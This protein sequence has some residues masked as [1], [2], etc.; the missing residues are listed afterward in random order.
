M[1]TTM[2]VQDALNI[3]NVTESIITKEIIKSAY[4]TACLKYHPDHHGKAGE[5]MM[6]LVNV[7][8]GVIKK[9]L[10]TDFFDTFRNAQQ[11][12]NA[13]QEQRTNQES[14][15]RQTNDEGFAYDFGEEIFNA[16]KFIFG[17]HYDGLVVELCGNWL[18]ITGDTKP[19]KDK[20]KD[21]RNQEDNNRFRWC[22]KKVAWSYRP[23]EWKSSNRRAWSMDQIRAGHG[24]R[25]FRRKEE[26]ET[27]A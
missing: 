12:S 22:R 8:Y 25:K 7:A 23:E 14:K 24:S 17:L 10:R 4:S 9:L 26:T 13:K 20:I 21:Y 18:W 19:V 5:E 2:K 6:K 15:D 27:A 1:K 11:R 16:L 3:L